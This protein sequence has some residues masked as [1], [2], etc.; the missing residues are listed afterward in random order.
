MGKVNLIAVTDG[1]GKRLRIGILSVD[2]YLDS[3]AK[4]TAPGEEL[5]FELGILLYHFSKA[6]ADGATADINAVNAVN[7]SLQHGGDIDFY[8]HCI[9]NPIISLLCGEG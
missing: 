8:I 3:I 6:L 7:D 4:F 2:K 9:S 1:A 5:R